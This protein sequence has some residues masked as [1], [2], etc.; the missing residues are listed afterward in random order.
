MHEVLDHIFLTELSCTAVAKEGYKDPLTGKHMNSPVT[1]RPN[2]KLQ[3]SIGEWCKQ[4]GV[5]FNPPAWPTTEADKRI[6]ENTSQARIPTRQ[7]SRL[8]SF[9]ELLKALHRP[10]LKPQYYSPSYVREP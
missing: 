6:S 10:S 9:A 7:N 8:G 5:P 3:Q 1:L 2:F 4:N